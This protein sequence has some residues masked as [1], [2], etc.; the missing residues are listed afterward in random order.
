[1]SNS[2]AKEVDDEGLGQRDIEGL[3]WRCRQR[4][5]ECESMMDKSGLADVTRLTRPG[6]RMGKRESTPSLFTLPSSFQ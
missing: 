4:D 2:V 1:M 3:D 5:P 6:A